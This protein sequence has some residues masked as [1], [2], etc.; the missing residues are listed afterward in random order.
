MARACGA[1]GSGDFKVVMGIDKKW[2]LWGQQ[3]CLA[4]NYSWPNRTKIMQDGQ[5][6]NPPGVAFHKLWCMLHQLSLFALLICRPSALPV[7]GTVS[8]QCG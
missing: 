8:V 6:D 4:A 7:C 5:C 2:G 3:Y 1:D